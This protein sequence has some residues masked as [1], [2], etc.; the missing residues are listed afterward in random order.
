MLLSN[1]ICLIR[2]IRVESI[3]ILATMIL[4]E[5]V[6]STLTREALFLLVP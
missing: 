5:T 3:A 4:K 1:I 6:N 2:T